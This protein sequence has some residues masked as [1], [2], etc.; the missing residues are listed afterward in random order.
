VRLLLI[1]D[2]PHIRQMMRLTLEAVGYEVDE[3]AD[4]EAGLARFRS[5]GPY[6]AV[7]LDQKMPGLDG[8]ETLQRLKERAP[9]VCVLMATAFASIELAVDAMR[10]GATDFLRKPMTPEALRS[11]VAAA[12]ASGRSPRKVRSGA[13]ARV[14][15]PDIEMLTLNGFRIRNADTRP[16]PSSN[17]HHFLVKHF[18]DGSEFDVTVAI[19]PEGVDRVAR[20][21]RRRLEPGGA[22]WRLQAERLLSA[23]LWSEGKG[24]EG[25]RL[26]VHD[27][28]RDD[29]DVALVWDSD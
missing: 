28:S 29:L 12:I 19:D 5:G 20:L 10:M 4:G 2:E 14:G 24:P 23:Y 15:K 18:P 26:T 9:D 1:D 21:T 3:A 6:D 17:E 22:F 25:G 11:A 27:V 13:A 16:V 7:V 8:L